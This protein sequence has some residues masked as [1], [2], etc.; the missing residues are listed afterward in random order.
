MASF[1][2]PPESEETKL[3]RFEHEMEDNEANINSELNWDSL[4][5]GLNL[6]GMDVFNLTI[7]FYLETFCVTSFA[8]R[9]N[10]KP[11]KTD[12]MSAF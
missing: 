9:A 7:V 4:K 12:E 6:V 3:E 11:K 10:P 1:I 2:D 8:E 5:E